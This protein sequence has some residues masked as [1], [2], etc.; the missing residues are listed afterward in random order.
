MGRDR[1]LAGELYLRH[2][3]ASWQ[4]DD[5]IS[6]ESRELTL[7]GGSSSFDFPPYERFF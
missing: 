7:G 3:D 6:E 5:I 2:D 4:L 1:E